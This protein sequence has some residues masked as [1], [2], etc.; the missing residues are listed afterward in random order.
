MAGETKSIGQK[1]KYD[2]FYTKNHVAIKCIQLI[3]RIY[4]LEEFDCIIEPAAG[5]GAFSRYLIQS[6]AYDIAP[7]P[8]DPNINCADWFEVDKSQFS[9]FE[10]ILVIGNP[11]FGEQS[12][13]AIDFFNSCGFANVIA[14]IMPLSFKKKS[15]MNRLDLR[16]HL[17]AEIDLDPQ[18]F[19]LYGDD[20][21]VPCVFQVWEKRYEP[22]QKYKKKT[23]TDLFEFVD[24]DEADFRVAR[25]GGSAGKASYDLDY[26]PNS[27]YFIK[28]TTPV[29]SAE[30]LYDLIN[31]I[32][33]PSVE[34][35]VGPK[36]LSKTELI[37]EIEARVYNLV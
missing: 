37:E 23:T 27:N 29:V 16:F 22:R 33:F 6:I 2:R 35:T 34:W 15:M 18:S 17:R 10:N 19:T 9:D 21:A 26:S 30:Q 20:Y 32:K 36:S 31:E 14:F 11:P 5:D 1:D 8:A 7:D 12:R 4:G 25:V 28:A 24:K 13:L 3:N